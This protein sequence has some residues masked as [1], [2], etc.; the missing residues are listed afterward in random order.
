LKKYYEQKGKLAPEVIPQ[1]EKYAQQKELEYL[2]NALSEK[3]LF[4]IELLF[5]VLVDLILL[6]LIGLP[7]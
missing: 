2:T 4:H 1:I 6:Q 5:S 7:R 3:V